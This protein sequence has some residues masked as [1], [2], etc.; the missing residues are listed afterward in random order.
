MQVPVLSVVGFANS[1]KTTFL[2][3]LLPELGRLGIKVAVFKHHGH[4][5]SLGVDAVGKDTWRLSQAGAEPVGLVQGNSVTLHYRLNET[6]T[7]QDLAALVSGVDLVITEGFKR[8]ANPK[9]E[10]W[11]HAD[12]KEPAC[13]GD[14]FLIALV[15][16][17]RSEQEVPVF[18]LDDY[19]GVARFVVDYFA[20][21]QGD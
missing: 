5:D 19:R 9:I 18:A 10:I 12:Q 2:E 13:A 14:P 17:R 16:N 7:P 6:A 8:A 20:L 1:G 15:T 21:K 11:R 4:E 3:G